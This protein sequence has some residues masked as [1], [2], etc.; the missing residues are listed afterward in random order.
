[1]VTIWGFLTGDTHR[2]AAVNETLLEDYFEHS[3]V[4]NLKNVKKCEEKLV[5]KDQKMD[6][7]KQTPTQT[8]YTPKRKRLVPHHGPPPS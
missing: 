5:K 7:L 4:K 1:M 2:Q 3:F 8:F 6:F